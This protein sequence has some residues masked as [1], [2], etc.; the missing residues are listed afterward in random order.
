MITIKKK[1][2]INCIGV[3]FAFFNSYSILYHFELIKIIYI[4]SVVLAFSYIIYEFSLKIRYMELFFLFIL[5]FSCTYASPY[6]TINKILLLVIPI[7][8]LYLASDRVNDSFISFFK[9]II[10]AISISYLIFICGKF[11]DL[12][13]YNIIHDDARVYYCD[14]MFSCLEVN[15]E[16]RFSFIFDEPGTLA[17]LISIT[18]SIL[19]N[20][21]PNTYRYILLFLGFTTFS[22]FFFVYIVIFLSLNY[23]SK[24]NIRYFAIVT[25]FVVLLYL[26]I[27][28]L[29]AF[30]DIEF[31][32]YFF[33]KRFVYNDYS[34]IVG[35]VD[36]RTD[37]DFISFYNRLDFLDK[38]FGTRELIFNIYS[39]WT[40]LSYRNYILEV[41]YLSLLSLSLFY[42]Y[43]IYSKHG[44][45]LAIVMLL[46]L[47]LYFYQ[48]PLFFRPEMMGLSFLM[49]SSLKNYKD[50][51]A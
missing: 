20:I 37:I 3:I 42:A 1:S 10:I 25:A 41:G 51:N 50:S 45:R 46:F 18:I 23:L 8:A 35:I 48:R 9:F 27:K 34:I 39:H 47:F 4:T 43:Y 16:W 11:I 13:T 29:V 33:E 36:N 14:I 17:G 31:I 28:P 5:I 49:L 22:L 26:N 2:I 40:G 19:W 7:Y 38:L 30:I 21:M 15:N 24:S 6:T 32:T 12:P 44:V